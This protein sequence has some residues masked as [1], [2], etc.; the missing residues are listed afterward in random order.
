[1]LRR[2]QDSFLS[3]GELR[4]CVPLLLDNVRHDLF[5]KRR[6]LDLDRLAFASVLGS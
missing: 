6:D 2:L 4:E 5:A 3:L 1:M